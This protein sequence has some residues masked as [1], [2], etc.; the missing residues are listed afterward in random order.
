MGEWPENISNKGGRLELLLTVVPCEAGRWTV[1]HAILYPLEIYVFFTESI[2]ILYP[3]STSIVSW[4]LCLPQVWQWRW[5][6]ILRTMSTLS[7]TMSILCSE[8]C[9]HLPVLHTG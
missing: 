1:E 6:I 9:L 5:M 7:E 3:L 2:S 8:V 4:N